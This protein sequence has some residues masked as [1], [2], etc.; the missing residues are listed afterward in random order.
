MDIY[1]LVDDIKKEYQC[2]IFLVYQVGSKSIGIDDINSDTDIC[3]VTNKTIHDFQKDNI[4][5]W[6]VNIVE[7]L[8]EDF[9]FH[10]SPDIAILKT[11][12][13]LYVKDLSI[14][15]FIDDNK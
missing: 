15:N 13:I 11:E 3:V 10:F 9:I 14:F 5:I 12:N 2:E 6:F 8:D 7:S 1:S 4:D